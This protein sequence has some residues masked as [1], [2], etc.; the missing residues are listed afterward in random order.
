MRRLCLVSLLF[1]CA[2]EPG[3]AGSTPRPTGN[4]I[5]IGGRKLHLVCQGKGSPTVILESGAGE[6]SFDWALVQPKISRTTRV[7]AYDR[8]GYAWS[9]MSPG[10]E[11]FSFVAHDL[12]ELLRK[13]RIRP[14]YVL[15]G[16]AFGALYARNYQ[17]RFPQEVAGLVL[18]DPTPEE[19]T[20]VVMF[21][22]TVSLIDMAD[23]D[24]KAWPV[25][26]F[27]PSRTSPPPHR[28][29]LPGTTGGS[30]GP[31][32]NKLSVRLQASRAWALN[33][34]FDELDALTAEQALAVMESERSTLADLYDDRH[35]PN[36]TPLK[37]PLIILSRGKDTT[38][39]TV[40]MQ[41]ELT[42]LSSNT[43]HRT[44]NDSG[45]QI[46]IEDPDLVNWAVQKMI[47]AVR[48]SKQ[49]NP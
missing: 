32:F 47:R 35:N 27:A 14:P 16:H 3:W 7:C 1:V 39:E 13:A 2:I 24:L 43:I 21:G 49:L 22:K 34:L 42:R 10:F 48:T 44:A 17:R 8:A 29:S 23:H 33:R 6:F 40:G 11:Q 45:E 4:L 36:I 31:P 19:D 18:L 9:D 37:I 38:P 12:H 26:P 20:Q 15:V 5:D 30:I 41:N 28:A 25:R 46:E